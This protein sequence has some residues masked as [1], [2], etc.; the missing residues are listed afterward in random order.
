M[1]NLYG[2]FKT[3]LAVTQLNKYLLAFYFLNHPK[4]IEGNLA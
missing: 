1:T 3:T 2:T 4:V